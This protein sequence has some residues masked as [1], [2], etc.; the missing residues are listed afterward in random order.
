[1]DHI[2]NGIH[3]TNGLSTETLKSFFD[4]LRPMGEKYLKR[5]SKYL[6][7]TKYNEINLSQLPI[8]KHVSNKNDI[9]GT[10]VICTGSHKCFSIHC[11]LRGKI[12]KA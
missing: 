2:E 5:I 8:Q 7:C 3:K 11:I 12:F 6:D 1:M 9:K 4:T 10:N